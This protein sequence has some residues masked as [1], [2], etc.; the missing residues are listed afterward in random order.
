MKIAV[1][2]THGAGKSTFA[3]KIAHH[4]RTIGQNVDI[5][6]E[7]VRYSPFKF[8]EGSTPQTAMWLYHNQ[9]C[10]ELESSARG[11]D[12]IVCDRSVLDCLVYAEYFN[13]F[14]EYLHYLVDSAF[15]WMFTYDKIFLIQ[16]DVAL[17]L[18]GIRSEDEAFRDGVAD[19]FDVVFDSIEQDL[20][21]HGVEVYRLRSSEI[22]DKGVSKWMD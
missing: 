14:N 15:E 2:G 4:L 21:D 18:D 20:K 7:R 13:I 19:I 16:P 6:Q 11:F 17:T 10:R 3:L 12:T 8:N 9:V 5:I 22:M 1:V